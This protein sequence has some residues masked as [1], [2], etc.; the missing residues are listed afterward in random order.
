MIKI[1]YINGVHQMITPDGSFY[2]S[3]VEKK[4]NG[5]LKKIILRGQDYRD[6]ILDIAEQI[7]FDNSHIDK[8]HS[9]VH[10]VSAQLPDGTIVNRWYTP[11]EPIEPSF[12]QTPG[13]KR[14]V[15]QLKK[16]SISNGT[17]LNNLA[18]LW[19]LFPHLK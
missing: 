14:H 1:T 8:L 6:H 3:V 7:A 10:K 18:A 2:S 13:Y 9:K 5:K 17:K 16:V 11:F 15:K 12:K 19:Y 4:V